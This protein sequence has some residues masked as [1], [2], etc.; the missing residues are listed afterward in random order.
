M[1]DS[2]RSTLSQ[3]TFDTFFAR[4]NK[5]PDDTLTVNET[6]QCLETELCRPASE[7]KRIDPDESAVDTSA[8]VT[9]SATATGDY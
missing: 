5:F 3:Q 9:P 2:L 7:K 1:L 6:I 4:F 8:P